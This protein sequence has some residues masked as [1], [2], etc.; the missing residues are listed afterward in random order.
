VVGIDQRSDI[1]L[2]KIS[3]SGLPIVRIGDSSKLEVG[4]WSSQ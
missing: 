1:A 2:L 3:A 4:E